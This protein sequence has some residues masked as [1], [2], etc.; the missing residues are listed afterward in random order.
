MTKFLA[1]LQH[2]AE[3]GGDKHPD[4]GLKGSIGARHG[5]LIYSSRETGRLISLR[6][7]K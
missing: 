4:F 2:V 3:G 6:S 1:F 7:A 5:A